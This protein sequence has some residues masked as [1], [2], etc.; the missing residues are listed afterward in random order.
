MA[1]PYL[2]MSNDTEVIMKAP[3]V[4][5]LFY[6]TYTV[7]VFWSSDGTSLLL[8]DPT[9]PQVQKLPQSYKFSKIFPAETSQE[10]YFKQTAQPLVQVRHPTVFFHPIDLAELTNLL[11]SCSRC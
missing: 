3:F 6:H 9:R 5:H 7:L 10:E 11:F 4:R 1:Q 8:Q 2:S